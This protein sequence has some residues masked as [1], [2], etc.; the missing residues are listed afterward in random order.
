MALSLFL[1]ITAC[2]S[3]VAQKS[4]LSTQQSAPS[5][6]CRVIQHRLGE[7]CIPLQPQRIITLD[8]Q[9]ILDCLLVLDVKPVGT[10]IDDWGG[11]RYFPAVLPELVAGIDS[12]GAEGTPSLEKILA[13]KPDLILLPDY[14]AQIYQPLSAIA[15]TVLIDVWRDNIPIKENF[16]H[17]AQLVGKEEKAEE[18]LNQYQ[19]RVEKFREQLSDRLQNLEISVISHYNN[20]FGVPPSNAAYFQV[21]KDIGLPIKPV[22]LEQ[23]EWATFSIEV[24]NRYDADILFI[25]EDADE[26]GS[27]S[28]LSQEPLILSLEAVK[29]DRAYIVS[30][31]IWQFHGPIGM[32]L[33]LNDLSK[34]LLENK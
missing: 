20:Q 15:P 33:L 13:L 34:Y 19:E 14:S 28:Y 4:N 8:V 30:P 17:I 21:M 24:I 9:A 25:I 27:A 3:P 2:H 18:V 26:D 10:A 6:E 5:S 22:F 23:D 16:R 29:N 12:V 11:G 7:T 1:T 31:K 32:N